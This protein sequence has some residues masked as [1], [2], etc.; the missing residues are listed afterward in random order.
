MIGLKKRHHVVP[1]FYLRRFANRAGDITAVHPA[2][3]FR[4]Y[5][6]SIENVAVEGHF[7]N[8]PTEEG[9]VTVVEDTLSKLESIAG[10]D[11]PRLAAGRS[12]QLAAFRRRLSF[13]MAVQFVRGRSSHE[14]MVSF[15][16]DLFLKVAQIST[17]EIIQAEAERQGRAMTIEEARE[18]W[19][20]GQ[21]PTLKVEF[22]KIGP[23]QLPADSLVS[24]PHVFELGRKLIP[25]FY[26][27]VWTLFE[28]DDP[29][30]MTSDEPV[31]QGVDTRV[32]DRPAGL[33]QAETVVF[34]LDPH[35]ALMMERPDRTGLPSRAKG[36]P[37]LA[38]TFNLLVAMRS[39]KQLFFHPDT[40]PLSTLNI[41]GYPPTP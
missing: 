23:K 36:T 37:E 10:H 3:N 1:K 28:F 5:T 24:A 25:F 30:L 31:A 13:F 7:Y 17:P 19:R 21:D 34:P 33:A 38:R 20:V 29:V 22:Q 15:T 40:D 32:P 16:K 8:L 6:T 14:A 12:I 2:E 35:R 11:L 9:W 26:E 39:T 41:P 18:V 4:R 27:R